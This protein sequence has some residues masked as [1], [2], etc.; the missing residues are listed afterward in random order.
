MSQRKGIMLCYPFT[1]GRLAKW[2]APYILQPKLDGERCRVLVDESGIVTLLSSEENCINS[3]PHINRAIESLHLRS[4][5]LDGELYVHGA[6]FSSLHSIISR[7]VEM[8]PDSQYME[9]HLFDIVNNS[10]QVHRCNQLI[11]TIPIRKT[12]IP[13]YSPI[14]IVPTMLVDSLDDILLQAQEW[15]QQGYEGFIVR[16]AEAPYVRK[17]STQV[18]KFKPR[19]EDI[20]EIIDTQEEIDKFGVAK[21]TL[22][23]LV[24]RGNDETLFNVGSG[25][26]L[27]KEARQSLWERRAT[28]IGKWARVKYQ[29][30]TPGRQVPRF[31]VVIEIIDSL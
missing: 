31:P 13:M 12:G 20:Y 25:S 18:M 10:P 9:L 28:L 16:D 8:H 5:E 1:E 7:K 22:G 23:A 21:G 15:E 26:L 2:R 29:H 4:V 3:V 30:I 14:H 17:R 11:S 24:C 19:K 6:D 27:T